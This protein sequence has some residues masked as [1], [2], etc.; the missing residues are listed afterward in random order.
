VWRASVSARTGK[1]KSGCA[2]CDGR[3]INIGVNDLAT[4]DPDIAAQAHGWDPTTVTGGSE[5]RR[6]W[7]CQ[8]EHTWVATVKS[9]TGKDANGCPYCSNKAVLAGYNDLAT[10]HPDIAADAHGW[11]PTT[12]SFGSSKSREWQCDKG[13][14]WSVIVVKRT[15]RGFGCPYCSNKAVLAGYNDLATTHPD[16]AADA[17]GWD[18]TTVSMG[19]HKILVWQCREGHIWKAPSNSRTNQSSG[20]P[21][22]SNQA[23]LAG[24]NDLATTH[25]DIAAQA[26]GW[27]PNTVT[28]GTK[29]KFQWR[30]LRGHSWSASVGQRAGKD[31]TGCPYCSNKVVLAGYNDL[32]TTH[33]DIA[34]EAHGWD[35]T[36]L[37]FGSHEQRWWQC[38]KGHIWPASVDRRTGPNKSGCPICSGNQVFAG[39]NDLATTHPD[40]A[41]QAHGWDPTTVVGGSNQK[42]K[43]WCNKGHTWT[44][45]IGG[46][47]GR[48]KNGCTICANKVVLVG[49]NDLSTTHPDIAAQA[50]EWDPTTVV[51]G[52][53]QKRKWQCPKGHVWS[54]ITNNR[55]GSGVGCPVCD[56]KVIL[57]GYNDLAT[58]HPD[59]AAQAH[60]WD[61]TTVVG[62]NHQ[63]R[64]WQCPKGHGW[65]ATVDSRTHMESGCPSCSQ[66]GFDPNKH[67][68]LY[69]LEHEH[70]GLLQIGISNVPKS[71]IRQ[72]ELKGWQV[73]EV[74][75][76][77]PGDITFQWEQ[78]IL[79]ALKRRGVTLG[80][81][82]IAGRFSG[83]TEAWIRED[84]PVGSLKELMDLVYADD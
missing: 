12:V 13:H 10:T 69:F 8:K 30:C 39:Y 54:A 16:I 42:R 63:K 81:E 74:R 70:W 57:A 24:Y 79:H 2:V 62:G 51:G 66:S 36:T 49:Y 20:C 23:V 82:E 52:S 25:P 41:A 73:L 67:G 53:N 3:Q 77:I 33:P 35:P 61:P 60:G 38:G 46:R 55:T 56:N 76:P 50:F 45:S 80:P 1:T 78:D 34:A 64:Q 5:K 29:R 37:V 32:A 44:A 14:V 48:N 4:T 47:T 59:I 9:R 22:C 84:F 7:R 27:D 43:W 83:Y 71:R 68:W 31:K 40:I 65:L 58:T 21:Y 11:D 28:S 15:Q 6:E 26:H 17:H 19:S 72:H 75:G 18:P